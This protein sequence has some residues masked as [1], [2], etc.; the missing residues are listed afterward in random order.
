M[1]RSGLDLT[2]YG[3]SL[4][5]G[6]EARDIL[7]LQKDLNGS[8]IATLDY[9]ILSNLRPR[10]AQRR[11]KRS[12]ENAIQTA[13]LLRDDKTFEQYNPFLY[14]AVHGLTPRS[15]G[16]YVRTLFKQ[17]RQH[18]L[19]DLNFGLAIGSLVPLRK[20]ID[21]IVNLI[22]ATKRAIPEEF[23]T[24]RLMTGRP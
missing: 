17:M 13:K 24:T 20:K 8:I 4:T 12:R 6:N 22:H 1:Y 14:M 7:E 2:K 9:P 21:L 23:V 16:Y 10:E 3:I 15:I 5:P 19:A 18:E 11:M